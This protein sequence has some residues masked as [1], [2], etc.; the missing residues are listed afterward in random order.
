MNT[1]RR[2]FGMGIAV[3]VI[4][5]FGGSMLFSSCGFHRF[6]HRGFH[7]RYHGKGLS[8]HI[9]K[10]MDKKVKKLDLS[11][12]QQKRYEEIRRNIA[13]DLSGMADNHR[14][15]FRELKREIDREN[16]DMDAVA[17]LVKQRIKRMPGMMEEAT[18]HFMD[19][20]N[21]L[22]DNQKA[23]VIDEMRKKMKRFR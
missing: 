19:F 9:M 8:E 22:D 16:P 1:Q 7:H 18:D 12:A 6:P 5:F 4:A 21:A 3:L 15:F 17:N 13:D 10:R 23:K 2:Y 14:D 11:E 20:Y